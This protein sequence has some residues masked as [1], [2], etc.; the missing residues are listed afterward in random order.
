MLNILKILAQK[1]TSI[2]IRSNGR[3][4]GHTKQAMYEGKQEGKSA[5]SARQIG[6]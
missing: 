6:C 2:S 1:N 3:T 4:Y 5:M